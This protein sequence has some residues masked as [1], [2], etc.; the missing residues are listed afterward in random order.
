MHGLNGVI[1][2][3]D[4]VLLWLALDSTFE[5]SGRLYYWVMLL[6]SSELSDGRKT[7][8]V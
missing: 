6:S 7:H 8:G 4:G 1:G 2:G 3:R 5:I